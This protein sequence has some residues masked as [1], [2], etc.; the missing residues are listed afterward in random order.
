V[1]PDNPNIRTAESWAEHY[2]RVKL[3]KEKLEAENKE[4]RRTIELCASGTSALIKERDELK[5]ENLR[6]KS[7]SAGYWK[8]EYVIAKAE[9]ETMRDRVWNQDLFHET[10]QQY[11]ERVTE[12]FDLRNQADKLAAALDFY[13]TLCV[14]GANNHHS[15]R[16]PAEDA[17]TTYQKF[18]QGGSVM[19]DFNELQH[20]YRNEAPFNKMVN[21]FT[22]LIKE[23]GFTPSEIREGL[24]YA[25]YTYEIS[26]PQML[27]TLKDLKKF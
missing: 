19:F 27:M 13:K 12:L 5:L 10:E 3:E 7:D 9:V 25:Q 23:H 4:F 15:C 1:N 24:F 8:N 6:L 20:K 22:A 11:N 14:H 17:I 18:K 16:M 26:E 21:M 2:D